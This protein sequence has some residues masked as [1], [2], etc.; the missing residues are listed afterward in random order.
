MSLQEKLQA[1][2][3]HYEKLGAELMDPA[4]QADYR[5]VAELSRSRAELEPAV[6]AYQ[7]L[8]KLEAQLADAREL[9]SSTDPEMSAMA[10]EEMEDLF[11]KIEKTNADLALSLVPPDPDDDKNIVV[12]IRAGT[13]GEESALFASDLVSMY[14]RF[15]ERHHLKMEFIDAHA[16]EIGGFKEVIFSIEGKGA[17][18]L[19][20]Y[21][22]GVHRVQRV[23]TT[24]ASGRIHTSAATVAV[25]PE[26]DEVEVAVKPE[27]LRIDVFRSTG[28]GGQSVNTTDSAV[29]ITHIPTGLVVTCQDEK[30]Q[31]KNKAKAL[32]VLYARLLEK[33]RQEQADVTSAARRSQ[34]GSGDR[35]ERIRTYNFPQSRLT[36]HRI[37]LTLYRLPE[38]MAGDLDEVVDA[39]AQA[40]RAEKLGAI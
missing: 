22:S 23:P 3:A 10:S 13:G 28:P 36:D 18:R 38:I 15:A 31:H 39:L 8:T 4:V 27:E 40:D 11:R 1:A 24:E 21:E 33:A 17:F 29:R 30:S 12:E 37:G 35:S 14:Q 20:K 34:I 2:L 6:A 25:L 9:S 16:T 19:F 26:A 32:K 5:R 7:L